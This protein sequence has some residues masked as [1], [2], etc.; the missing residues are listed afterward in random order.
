MLGRGSISMSMVGGKCCSTGGIEKI[1]KRIYKKKNTEL[2]KT[3]GHFGM[4]TRYRGG[5]FHK[6]G[7]R[8]EILKK[9]KNPAIFE[10]PR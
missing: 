2:V 5:V 9:C 3:N 1:V 7:G 4:Y 10:K 6:T 8:V